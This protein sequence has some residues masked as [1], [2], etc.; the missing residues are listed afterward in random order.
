MSGEELR[1]LRELVS[2]FP[3][4]PLGS[5]T[6]EEAVLSPFEVAG[7]TWG[8][9]LAGVDFAPGIPGSTPTNV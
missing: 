4:F 2:L 9:E 5:P 3:A 6:W 7:A 1:L 8:D